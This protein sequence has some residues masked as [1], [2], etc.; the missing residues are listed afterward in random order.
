MSRSP[1]ARE[2]RAGE[3]RWSLVEIFSLKV[4]A[5]R[6]FSDAHA[7]THPALVVHQPSSFLTLRDAGA[8]FVAPPRPLPR[9][10]GG[11]E[12]NASHA[13]WSHHLSGRYSWAADGRLLL[14]SWKFVW[15]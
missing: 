12:C 7:E 3:A 4:L 1:G 13:G 8:T 6:N 9:G 11:S 14:L 10:A 15:A 5:A 2:G